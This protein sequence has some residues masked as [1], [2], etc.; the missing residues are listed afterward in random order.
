MRIGL[1]IFLAAF[2]LLIALSIYAVIVKIVHHSR[3]FFSAYSRNQTTMVISSKPARSFNA[4]SA[5]KKKLK[6]IT[7][8]N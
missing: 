4:F 8:I 1:L 6:S 3:D 5:V 2:M 7:F